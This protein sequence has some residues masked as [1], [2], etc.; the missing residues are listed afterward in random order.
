MT[1]CP[2]CESVNIYGPFY[3]PDTILKYECLRYICEQCG[4]HEDHPT[5]DSARSKKP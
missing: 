4:Y 3:R 5:K 1:I 2:K